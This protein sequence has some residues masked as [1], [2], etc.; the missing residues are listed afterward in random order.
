MGRVE[1]DDNDAGALD[2]QREQPPTLLAEAGSENDGGLDKGECT[3][4]HRWCS[5]NLA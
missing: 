5:T 1:G 3:D 4:P 2:H